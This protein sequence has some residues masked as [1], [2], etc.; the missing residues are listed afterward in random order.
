MPRITIS[1]PADLKERLQHPAVKQSVNISKVCQKALS[2]VVHRL[3]DLPVDVRR[4]EFLLSRLLR[5]REA[6]G[7]RWFSQGTREARD[8]AEHEADHDA[9]GALGRASLDRRLAMLRTAPPATLEARL[10]SLRAEPGF[11]R[12]AFLEGWAHMLGLLWS[13]I[14]NDL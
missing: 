8:W 4:M 12:D 2:R 1:I 13:V 9:L 6:A 7:D 10:A 5:E 3:L 11:D 14:K